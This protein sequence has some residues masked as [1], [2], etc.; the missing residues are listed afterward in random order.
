MISGN[1]VASN[2]LV[3]AA[4][5]THGDTEA[6]KSGKSGHQLPVSNSPQLAEV[7]GTQKF[8]QPPSAHATCPPER[9]VLSASA[10]QR[11][12]RTGVTRAPRDRAQAQQKGKKMIHPEAA[13]T[14]Y[15][16][17]QPD[18]VLGRCSSVSHSVPGLSLPASL[19]NCCKIR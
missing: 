13:V 12:R 15:I 18:F 8:P 19:R 16:P 11:G 17:P 1:K 5:N 2:L 14:S 7:N 4:V 6:S 3:E 10:E 9:C